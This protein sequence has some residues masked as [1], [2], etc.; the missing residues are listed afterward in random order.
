[1]SRPTDDDGGFL[2][3]WARRKQEAKR[4]EVPVEAAPQEA[5][6]PSPAADPLPLP[7]LDDVLPGGD[8]SAFL[9]AHVPDAL[10]NAALR[11]L[12]TSDPEISGFIEMADYQ[13]DF[14]N[15]DAIPGWSSGLAGDDSTR[16]LR[17]LVGAPEPKADAPEPATP[18][19]PDFGAA[20]EP[21]P[22]QGLP[23]PPEPAAL[24][25]GMTADA[26]VQNDL[27]G[28]ESYPAS[29]KRHGGALPT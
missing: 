8:V 5:P 11:K 17:R 6:A 7:T 2:G 20:A 28:T 19:G 24:D 1:M 13:W 4:A 10:R 29:R 22:P 23:T 9:Q 25:E 15:P 26:A 12:W 21:Q 27:V 18:G 14:N 16:L 3:R